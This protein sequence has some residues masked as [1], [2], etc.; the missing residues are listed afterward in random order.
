[1]FLIDRKNPNGITL[2][3]LIATIIILI[4]LAGT[5]VNILMGEDGI[6]KKAVEAR[7]NTTVA[8][9]KESISI[10]YTTLIE[11]EMESGEIIT[12]EKFE[13]E[14]KNLNKESTVSKDSQE[15]FIVE[16]KETKNK[17]K[18]EKNG[19]ITKIEESDENTK[20]VYVKNIKFNAGEDL[21]ELGFEDFF[22]DVSAKR[23]AI[24]SFSSYDGYLLE[25]PWANGYGGLISLKKYD[26]SKID[27]IEVGTFYG[28]NSKDCINTFTV[29]L[30]STNENNNIFDENLKTS[31]ENTGLT[32]CYKKDI[33]EDE[34]ETIE[35]NT[36]SVSNQYY[37]KVCEDHGP[38]PGAMTTEARVF[39]IK[40]YYNEDYQKIENGLTANFNYTGDYQ[41]YTVPETGKYKIE[42]YGARGGCN[43]WAGTYLSDYGLGGYESGI[44]ELTKGEKL[45]IYVGKKGADGVKQA[46]QLTSTSFNGGGA[47]IGSSDNDDGGGAGGGAT[48]VRLVAGNWDDFESLKSRIIV[49]GG[50]SGGATVTGGFNKPSGGSGGGLTGKGSIWKYSNTEVSNHTYNGTQ[51]TGYKFGIGQNAITKGNTGGAGAGGGYYGGYTSTDSPAGGAGGGSGYVSGYTGCN[52]ITK[53]STENNITHTG[54]SVHYSG[55][56]FT[57]IVLKNE[58]NSKSGYAVITKI[59]DRNREFTYTGNYQEYVVPETGKYKI[60][61][62]GARGGC[63]NWAGTYLSDYGLGGY[64]S[65]TIELIKGEKL[66]IYV[67]Q[68]GADGVKQANQ[69]TSTSFNGGGAGI[70]SSDN[71]DGGGAGGGATDVRLVAGNWDDFESL[72]SR[73]IVAGGGSGGATVTGGFNKPS[74]G[75]GGGLTGK[76]SIWKYSNTEVSNHTYNAT[77]TTGYKFGIG[78]NAI[79]KGNA[80]GAGAGGGYYG[81]YTSTD[82]PA[83][84][85]GG[86]SGYVSGYAGCNSITKES[87]ENNI[88]HTGSSV[89]YSGKVFTNIE[90]KDSINSKEGYVKIQKQ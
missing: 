49:A 56:V 60:E 9:E 58:V 66:Y 88:T 79:T 50:G 21:E 28:A 32:T 25:A 71:D 30:C 7:K 33:N 81:G 44:I 42:C 51:T 37:I 16:I 12:T 53:E 75:S 22:T 41:E 3:S 83:G 84:G 24:D 45:Y 74:G 87:T 64:A 20:R 23:D 35:L 69:L 82:N 54:S 47:G 5:S 62:Y 57:D 46:N 10:A 18:V 29:G 73:I 77:Q 1:M 11:E 31:V 17:Y 70:G 61:C 4:I 89:H 67:G 40:I 68:T 27:K 48:D 8:L 13:N 15:N 85:A 52:S 14:L 80:G 36:T 72:K 34:I 2:I 78:Q 19:N 6:I 65:G 86:G 90:L 39:W 55:K 43:N 38:T 59:D 76:G 63:D 26:F